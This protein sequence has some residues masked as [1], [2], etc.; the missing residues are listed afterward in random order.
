[1]LAAFFNVILDSGHIPSDILKVNMSIIPKITAPQQLKDFRPISGP[2]A[3]AKVLEMTLLSYLRSKIPDQFDSS[4][5]GFV[6]KRSCTTNLLSF[7]EVIQVNRRAGYDSVA[8]FLDASKAFDTISINTIL[9]ALHSYSIC[10]KV[11]PLMEFLLKNRNISVKVGNSRSS[12]FSCSTGVPQGSV[13]APLL[14]ALAIA[15]VHTSLI[16][17]VCLKYADDL[18]FIFSIKQYSINTVFRKLQS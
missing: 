6:N 8:M 14:F 16:H 1:M 2:T 5:H 9:S 13:L 12:S 7:Q 11:L 4:Q 3:M 15:N 10:G 18:V 17:V